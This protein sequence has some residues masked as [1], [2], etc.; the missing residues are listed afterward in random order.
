M[1]FAKEEKVWYI[2]NKEAEPERSKFI[3]QK[4]QNMAVLEKK[5][6]SILPHADQFRARCEREHVEMPEEE[7]EKNEEEDNETEQNMEERGNEVTDLEDEDRPKSPLKRTEEQ[8]RKWYRPS[9]VVRRSNGPNKGV[10][11]CRFREV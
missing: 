5:G 7:H 6:Q 11:P 8:I 4:G 9:R 1:S 2:K 3:Q 10:K